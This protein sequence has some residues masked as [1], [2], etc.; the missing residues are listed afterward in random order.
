M[1]FSPPVRVHVAD[2]PREGVRGLEL[3]AAPEAAHELRLQASG[4]SSCPRGPGSRCSRCRRRRRGAA[5]PGRRCRCPAWMKSSRS[6]RAGDLVG[7]VGAK[8]PRALAAHVADLERRVARDLALHASRST[9]SC[10]R[11]SRR[12]RGRTGGCP[13]SCEKAP[14]KGSALLSSV[15]LPSWML[16]NGGL[17]PRFRPFCSDSRSIELA[18]AGAHAPSC[19]CRGRPTRSRGA[20]RSSCCVLASDAVRPGRASAAAR[21][22]A[23]GGARRQQHAVAGVAAQGRIE[24]RRVEARDGVADVVGA[25]EPRPAQ[26]VVERHARVD[27]PGVG[28]VGLDVAPAL[29]DRALGRVLA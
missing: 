19:R 14:G 2:G 10:S 4:R 26:A 5:P 11:T 8:E 22:L 3:R 27:L 16:L 13:R 18:E 1:P 29:L 7:V 20:A 15:R 12:Y 28:H 6:A 9:A 25:L 17:K 23:G 21:V 24:G